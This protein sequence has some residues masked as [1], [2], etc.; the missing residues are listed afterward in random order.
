MDDGGGGAQGDL[1]RQ[2]FRRVNQEVGR[3]FFQR[4]RR[5]RKRSRF[6]EVNSIVNSEWT[7]FIEIFSGQFNFFN[8]EIWVRNADLAVH[9][10]NLSGN[11]DNC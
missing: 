8:G 5:V 1:G 4:S 2:I 11:F 3:G 7:F 9:K 6:A 10:Y